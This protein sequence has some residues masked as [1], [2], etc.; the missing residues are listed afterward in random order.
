MRERECAH[1]SSVK[2]DVARLVEGADEIA[3]LQHGAE[4]GSRVAGIGAQIAVAQVGGGKQRRAAGQI[5]H[6]IALRLRA[7]A[8]RPECQRAAR[9]GR[10]L[11][12]V[13]DGHFERAEMALGGADRALHDRKFGGARRRRRRPAA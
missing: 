10:G 6:Q 7:V 2:V 8:R 4:H 13:V 11:R 1:R 3:R 12:I 9:R 5:E